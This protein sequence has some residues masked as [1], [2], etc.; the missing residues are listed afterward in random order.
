MAPAVAAL[1]LAAGFVTA[2][3]ALQHAGQTPGTRTG[4]EKKSRVS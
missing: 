4:R 1:A 3:V 2:F